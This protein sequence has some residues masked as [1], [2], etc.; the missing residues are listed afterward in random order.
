MMNLKI[1]EMSN[2]T[3]TVFVANIVYVA[4]AVLLQPICIFYP[5]ELAQV[6]QSVPC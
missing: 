5:R 3:L 2:L 6:L 1:L 4:G